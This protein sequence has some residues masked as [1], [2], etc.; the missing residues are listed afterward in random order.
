MAS[1]AQPTWQ[2]LLSEEKTKSYFQQIIAHINREAKAGKC[3]YP[4]NDQV[5]N[6]IK[7]TPYDAV[8]VV[9]IGQDPYHGPNQAHGLAFSVQAGIPQPPSL[10]NIFKEIQADLGIPVPN[11]GCL[12][13]WAKQGVLLLNAILTVQAGQPQSHA[14]IGWQ[15]FTDCIIQHLND[16]SEPIVYLLWGSYAQKKS[17]LIDQ[18][19]HYVLTAT[20]PSPLSAHRGFLGCRHFSK[21]NALL[22]QA[23]REPIDWALTVNNEIIEN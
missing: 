22:K 17:A 9:I 18:R 15:H 8:K 4:A 10:K 14:H 12:T 21:A 11:T 13:P 2:N 19:K 23:G 1:D 20:H 5:F 3:I 7:L 16:H 6:A